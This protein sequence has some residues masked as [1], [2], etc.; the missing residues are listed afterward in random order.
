[1]GIFITATTPRGVFIGT[2]LDAPGALELAERLGAFEMT[3]IKITEKG[4]EPV[5]LEEYQ[6]AHARPWPY[7]P[8]TGRELPFGAYIDEEK[9]RASR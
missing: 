8:P 1:M 2:A 7:R 4:Q 9:K 6:A 5:T 3:D